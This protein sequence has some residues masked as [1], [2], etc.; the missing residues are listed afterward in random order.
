MK[1]ESAPR[2]LCQRLGDLM[3]P[4]HQTLASHTA[5]SSTR[6]ACGCRKTTYHIEYETSMYVYITRAMLN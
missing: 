1:V 3:L 2:R 5:Y 6:T 4:S